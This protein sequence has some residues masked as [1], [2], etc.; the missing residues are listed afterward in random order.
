MRWVAATVSKW[1]VTV[2]ALHHT[3]AHC[4]AGT[5]LQVMLLACSQWG[6]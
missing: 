6:L 1:F 5:C 2:G 3:S 4:T